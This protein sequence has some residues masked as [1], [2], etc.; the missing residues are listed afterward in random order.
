MFCKRLGYEFGE[1]Y[2]DNVIDNIEVAEKNDTSGDV[3]SVSENH[4]SDA[5]IIGN[6]LGGDS[7]PL[8]TGSLSTN[9]NATP[10]SCTHASIQKIKCMNSTSF[11]ENRKSTC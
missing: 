9:E 5:S 3:G 4:E 10:Q 6:C 8:C 2:Q 7:W 1:I 11:I